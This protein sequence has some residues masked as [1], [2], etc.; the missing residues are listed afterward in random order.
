[1]EKETAYALLDISSPVFKNGESIPIK[2]TCDGLNVSPPLQIKGI[3]EKTACLAVILNDPDGPIGVWVHWLVWNIPV[4]NF[5]KENGIEGIEG[6]N[7]FQQHKYGGPCPPSGTH[8]YVFKVYAL[9]EL[10]NLLLISKQFQVEKAMRGHILGYG[11]LMGF[12]TRKEK[13]IL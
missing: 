1:M 8:R 10:L 7:D 13:H 5:I 6:I 3:P 12:Y 11:E 4:T 2:Y 9:D